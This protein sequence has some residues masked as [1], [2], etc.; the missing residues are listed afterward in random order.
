LMS[1][2][3]QVGVFGGNLVQAIST[4]AFRDDTFHAVRGLFAMAPD[5]SVAWMSL[6]EHEEVASQAEELSIGYLGNLVLLLDGDGTEPGPVTWYDGN[7][8]DPV[9]PTPQELAGLRGGALGFHRQHPL[10]VTDDGRFVVFATD[11]AVVIVDVEAGTA[12][13]VASQNTMTVTAIDG[14]TAYLVSTDTGY[15]ATYD[16]ASGAATSLPEETLVPYLV[17]DTAVLFGDPS[18]DEAFLIT[19]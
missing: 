15:P 9:T 19:R 18:D 2:P 16:L 5:G 11:D 8:G 14:D 4:S 10:I 7:T 17:T 3:D 13:P 6:T 1:R 12:E